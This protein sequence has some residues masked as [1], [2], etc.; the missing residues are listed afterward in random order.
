MSRGLFKV[1]CTHFVLVK[2]LSEYMVSF[3]LRSL[4]LAIFHLENYASIYLYLKYAKSS[5]IPH[6]TK[7]N[8]Q[9]PQKI[10]RRLTKNIKSNKNQQL[11]TCYKL[12]R[13]IQIKY[14]FI[15]ESSVLRTDG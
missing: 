10:N 6:Y 7:N 14:C 12:Q 5:F 1:S 4:L 11:P 2:L 3:V 13:R 9:L 15:C 8:I